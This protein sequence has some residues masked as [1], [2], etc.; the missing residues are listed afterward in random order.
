MPTGNCALCQLDGKE[1]IDS[2]FFPAASYKAVYGKDLSVNE[3]MIVTEKRV[4]Q[5]SRQITAHAFCRDCEDRFNKGGESWTIE[6]LATLSAF[7]MREMVLRSLAIH[8]EPGF[9]AFSC[10]RISELRSEKIIHFAL[11]MFWK[12]SGRTWNMLDGPIPRLEFGP[13]SEPIRKFVYGSDPFPKHVCLIVF[14]DSR[15]PSRIALTPPQRF[16]HAQC[17]LFGFY[18]NGMQC[19]LCVGKNAPACFQSS[20]MATGQDRAIFV[21]PDAGKSMFAIVKEAAKTSVPSRGVMKTFEQWKSFR[22]KK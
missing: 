17:H 13:Y 12:A 15:T 22:E 4:I 21:V 16:E 1:L 6:K 3:P 18:M 10:D 5:S 19:W 7:P 2:H 14:L 11:G 9:K 20:C 8:D